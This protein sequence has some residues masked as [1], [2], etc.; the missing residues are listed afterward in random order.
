MPRQPTVTEIRLNSIVDSLTPVLPLLNELNDAFGTP[1]VQAISNTTL[2]LITAVQTVKR[3]KDECVQLMENI[4]GLLYAIINLHIKS[5]TRGSLA[6]IT[7]HHLG[8]FTET[9]H[10]IHMWVEVQQDGNKIKHFFRQNEIS[11][12]L[13]ECREGLQ[14][15]LEVFKIKDSLFTSI[16]E[17]QKTVDSSYKELAELI[18]TVSDGTS[19]RSSSEY[20]YPNSS[21][22][23][24]T[25]FSMLPSKP[26]IFHGRESE[27]EHILKILNEESPRITILGPGGMGKTS[28]ARATLHHPH[29]ASK[30]EHRFFVACDSANNSIAMAALLGTH[31]GLK[32]GKNLT[33][34]VLRYFS[35]KPSS[36]LILDNLETPWEPKD[37]RGDVEE[38]LSLLADIKHL[39]VIITMR[40][41]ERPAKV[42]WTR[43]FL[44]PLKPLANDAAWQTFVDIADDSHKTEDI[45]QLLQLADN[46]PLAVDLVAHLVDSEP[47]G[48]TNVLSRWETEKTSLL[49]TGHDRKSSLDASI[50]LSLSSS[51]MKSSPGA[52]DLLSLLSIL[53]DGLSD[54]E[55]LQ[56][57][58]SIQDILRCKATLLGT[59]LAYLDDNRRLKSLIPIREHVLHFHPPSAQLVEPLRNHFHLLLDLYERYGGQ[60]QIVSKM[61]QISS[62]LGNL[63]KILERGLH[64]GRPDLL[65]AIECTILLNSFT[66]LAANS[67]FDLMD[68]IPSVLPQPCNHRLEAQFIIETFNS[69]THHSVPTPQLLVDQAISHFQNFNDP[70]LETRFYQSVGF[71]YH[72][73]KND[74]SA[75]MPFLAKALMLARSSGDTKQQSSI[76]GFTAHI[77]WMLG[78]YATSWA[79]AC[80]AQRVAQMAA[81]CYREAKAVRT[82]ASCCMTLGDYKHSMAVISRGRELLKLCGLNGGAMD[83]IFMSTEAEVHGL[84]SEY[85]QARRIC[86]QILENTSAEGNLH[87]Y[88]FSLLNIADIDVV[89]GADKDAILQN[90]N[91]AKHSF[92]TSAASPN[93]L[94]CD[95]T[96]AA[97]YLREKNIVDAKKLFQKCLNL[98][99]GNMAESVSRCLE[100]LADTSQWQ[101]TDFGWSSKCTVVYLGHA[102]QTKR[103]LDL[104]KALQFLGDVFLS[105]GDEETAHSLFIVA[106]QGFTYMDVHHGRAQCMLRLGDLAQHR[107]ELA[108]A[109]ELWRDARP[110]FEQSSQTRDVAQI[111]ARL[112]AAEQ[113]AL[114]QLAM[115]NVPLDTH[116]IIDADQIETEEVQDALND[117]EKKSQ[118]D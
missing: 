94:F 42:R 63:Q 105:N 27:L 104:H 58:L 72:F 93:I 1:F 65:H 47:E 46:M 54:I 77:Q 69:C 4:H 91:K 17:M 67:W 61:D 73:S 22:H 75:A 88:A 113:K 103:K 80:E 3:N 20:Q 7:L 43:P 74:P 35:D 111:D 70:V 102:M 33:K 78:N 8:K 96:L 60:S 89:I 50:A 2:S 10:K 56:S 76:L 40:G 101:V 23:S 19:E 5:E 24:S 53:P 45:N 79:D 21:Q 32:P 98:S 97:L 71:Y 49:S 66:R 52:K 114:P 37:S 68:V 118:V 109:V 6:P 62:N 18:S 41:A 81:D 100:G 95:I 44:Q 26:K 59:S 92:K 28:L 57:K 90:L 115:L 116:S 31:L 106:L 25:L 82:E 13:K 51:R 14:E 55:L 87:G 83:F 112:G 36:L 30:Y 85:D 84:K 107:G 64:P 99:W 110:L 16:S 48:C 108:E 38:F 86:M 39:A 9:L 12:M 15:A 34:S 11:T 29:V 117:G